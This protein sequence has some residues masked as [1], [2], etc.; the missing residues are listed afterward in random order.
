MGCLA[1]GV[2]IVFLMGCIAFIVFAF[3]VAK[4]E[5]EIG[6]MK[7]VS[8][9]KVYF[10]FT[11]TGVDSVIDAAA[12]DAAIND[13]E[14]KL[15]NGQPSTLKLSDGQINNALDSFFKSKDIGLS[16]TFTFTGDKAEVTVCVPSDGISNG[17]VKGRFLNLDM[18]FTPKFDSSTKKI[19]LVPL[20]MF[21]F[22]PGEGDGS[23]G[24]I[25]MVSQPLDP[26]NVPDASELINRQ[27]NHY[28]EIDP[29][30]KLILD[31]ATSISIEN[32]NLVIE[33]K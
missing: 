20:S 9:E 13:F 28:L 25:S 15:Q 26:K 6:W 29:T 27:L 2:L 3:L 32:G 7:A 33:A 10:Q 30:G 1:S 24:L 5:Q 19:Q 14:A 16:P 21:F 23:A 8:S 11:P 12:T 22:T 4:G 31:H 18:T 17:T